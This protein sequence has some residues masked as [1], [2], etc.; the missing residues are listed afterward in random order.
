MVNGLAWRP[1]EPPDG[2]APSEE[3]IQRRADFEKLVAAAPAGIQKSAEKWSAGI[4]AVIGTIS[5][6]LLFKGPESLDE[7]ASVWWE[8]LIG[9]SVLALVCGVTALWKLLTVTTGRFKAVDRDRLLD[10]PG[11]LKDHKV[12]SVT[13]DSA[14]VRWAIWLGGVA[15]AAQVAAVLLWWVAPTRPTEPPAYVAV[16]LVGETAC[17][18]LLSADEQTI[19]LGVAGYNAPRNIPF[20]NVQN[21]SVVASC[22]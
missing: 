9:L 16:T 5:A 4:I 10:K 13:K 12:R 1:V 11:A 7:V 17:G 20:A 19:R 14:R 21:M 18:K 22:P 6:I 15:V 8:I 3:D 2:M